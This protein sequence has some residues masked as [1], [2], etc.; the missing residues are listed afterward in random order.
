MRCE[1][2]GCCNVKARGRKICYTHYT[3]RFKQNN[4]V[5]Y[6]FFVLKNN[7]KRRGKK[8]SL[9]FN[10]FESIINNTAYMSLKGRCSGDLSID[11]IKE[12]LGYEDGNIQVVTNKANLGKHY[13]WHRGTN[14]D[15]Q[16]NRAVSSSDF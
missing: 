15:R 6:A 7:A 9:S 13:G 2:D 14:L 5:K 10:H 16:F 8:F 1:I 4:P 12:E 11:R 3:Q